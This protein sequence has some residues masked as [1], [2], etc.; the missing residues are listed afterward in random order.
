MPWGRL[1]DK[2]HRN[3]KVKDL[4]KRKAAGREALGVWT[5][6]LSWCL[7][8]PAYNGV[9]PAHELPAADERGAKELVDVGLWDRIGDDY[10]FH[11]FFTYAQR[12]DQVETKRRADRE[13]VAVKR[14]ASRTD[15]ASESRATEPRHKRE[16]PPPDP[17][18]D[19]GL[20]ERSSL[21]IKPHTSSV[22]AG[23]REDFDI[24]NLAEMFSQRRKSAGGS[25]Y[26]RGL[27]D[28][29]KALDALGW[30][31][32]DNAYNPAESAAKSMSGYFADAGAK[33]EGYPFSWW[34]SD[35]GRYAA[36][37]PR[38]AAKGMA[39]VSSRAALEAQAANETEPEWMSEAAP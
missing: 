34:A 36:R 4:R 7:D 5:F 6:W 38:T 31:Q 18:P 25:A 21:P 11:D 15:V 29:N 26:K 16:S 8:D 28:Y 10:V 30:A 14:A 24:K 12:P 27:G 20:P 13:R 23:A 33:A 35:P 1:D 32:E 39:P 22:P 37:G 19:P 3:D 9:V 17:V 2:L